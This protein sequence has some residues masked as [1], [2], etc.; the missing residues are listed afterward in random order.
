MTTHE[1]DQLAA[2]LPQELHVAVNMFGLGKVAQSLLDAD[3]ASE[4]AV[5][6]RIGADLFRRRKEAAVIENGLRALDALGA[7]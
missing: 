1:L 5:Y 4:H 6:A 3:T 2:A 7:R